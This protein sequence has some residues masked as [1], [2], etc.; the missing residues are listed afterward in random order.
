MNENYLEGQGARDIDILLNRCYELLDKHDFYRELSSLHSKA[1]IETE[2]HLFNTVRAIDLRRGLPDEN[3]SAAPLPEDGT[4]YRTHDI[5]YVKQR[6]GLMLRIRGTI[7][8]SLTDGTPVRPEQDVG[9]GDAGG[10]PYS[11]RGRDDIRT[12][13]NVLQFPGDSRDGLSVERYKDAHGIP[14]S[15][16]RYR[17]KVTIFPGGS[18]HCEMYRNAHHPPHPARVDPAGR[19]AASEVRTGTGTARE[20]TGVPIGGFGERY[21]YTHPDMNPV[22]DGT[23]PRGGVIEF[24]LKPS[25]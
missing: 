13:A 23:K 4:G 25:V 2:L 22:R 5:G 8:D 24:K 16:R 9:Y 15:T 1:A 7:G 11:A 12:R 19:P 6:L 20:D 10:V 14:V 3:P 21:G 18:F 17:E